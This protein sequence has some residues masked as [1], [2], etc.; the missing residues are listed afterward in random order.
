MRKQ[1]DAFASKELDV[2]FSRPLAGSESKGFSVENDLGR[3]GENSVL[4][5]SGN[6]CRF[7]E[8]AVQRDPLLPFLYI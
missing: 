6:G 4:T 1:V 7:A 5:V 3:I 2:G 8:A